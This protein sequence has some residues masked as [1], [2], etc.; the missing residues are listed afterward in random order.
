MNRCLYL[1]LCITALFLFNA[2][3]SEARIKYKKA[4]RLGMIKD[5]PSAADKNFTLLQDAISNKRNVK[6]NGTFYVKFPKPIIL[7]YT[8][9]ISGGEMRIVSGNCFDFVDGGG[10]VAESTVFRREDV[11]EG[12]A[13]CGTWNLYGDIL[14]DKFD[15]LNSK[16]YGRYLVQLS[17]EDINSDETKFGI[18]QIHVKDSYLYNGGR[19]LFLNGVI[20]EKCNF[21]NNTFESF[22]VTPIYLCYSHSKKRYPA[23][24]DAYAYV[25]NNVK[26]SADVYICNNNFY[27]KPVTLDY[28][29]CSALVESVKCYFKNNILKD[30]INYTK[31]SKLPKATCYDAYLSCAEVYFTGNTIENMMSFSMNG[32]NKPQCE[33]GKSKINVL[34]G[35]G[36]QTVRHYEGNTYTVDGSYFLSLGADRE[37][38]YSNVF[39]N[40]DY[41][42]T[43]DWINNKIIYSNA[44][45]AG[46]TSSGGYGSFNISDNLFQ[47]ESIKGYG[48]CMM[49]TADPFN[50]IR[51]SNNNFILQEPSV[52]YL[53][54]Q[55]DKKPNTLIKGSIEIVNNRFINAVPKICYFIADEITINNN[56]IDDAKLEIN[57]NYYV[58]NY[59]GADIIP[60]VNHMSVEL[61]YLSSGNKGNSI[62]NLSTKSS[63]TFKYSSPGLSKSKALTGNVYLLSDK[64][65]TLRFTYNKDGKTID[66]PVLLDY[67]K[68]NLSCQTQGKPVNIQEGSYSVIYNKDGVLFHVRY[69]STSRKLYYSLTSIDISKND[70]GSLIDLQITL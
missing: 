51:I 42:D 66:V 59:T 15:F 38:L 68:G 5:D 19:I 23:E 43:Y 14:I 33:I 39:N 1:I 48:L 28:Y 49:S 41:V 3:D 47:V 26:K 52:F 37:S 46:R 40:F 2:N 10:F 55:V 9:H 53:F 35:E 58:T 29:Y 16:Y 22:P 7:D 20:W 70:E 18:N 24:A 30:I 57:S 4:T 45:L 27:G 54:N 44:D 62:V 6:L 13:L 32:G 34:D 17:F 56:K 67:Q 36:Y 60:D 31:G 12:K 8:L 25:E 63:G 50:R 64:T 65:L 11:D 69:N 21:S 61:P